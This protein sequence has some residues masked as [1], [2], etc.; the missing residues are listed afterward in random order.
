[1]FRVNDGIK[2]NLVQKVSL[3]LF[4]KGSDIIHEVSITFYI[5]LFSVLERTS[6]VVYIIY[7]GKYRLYLSH[8]VSLRKKFNNFAIV[9]L[10]GHSE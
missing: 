10:I 2:L 3:V 1:M 5:L 6:N 4:V 7:S 9:C 8:R